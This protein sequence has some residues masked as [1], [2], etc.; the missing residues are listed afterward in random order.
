M[1][2]MCLTCDGLISYPGEILNY[3]G[4]YCQCIPAPQYQKPSKA[5][6]DFKNSQTFFNYLIKM[7]KADNERLQKEVIR[8][9]DLLSQERDD[10]PF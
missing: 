6:F 1:S 8:L 4:K 9:K 3:S 7:L 5:N 2:D 10:N